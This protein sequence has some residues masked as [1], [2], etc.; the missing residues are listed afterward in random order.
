VELT[1]DDEVSDKNVAEENNE[2]QVNNKKEEL[3]A[4]G[5]DTNANVNGN[6][7]AAVAETVEDVEMTETVEEGEKGETIGD[8]FVCI[9]EIGGS[10]AGDMEVDK[11]QESGG[12]K[13]VPPVSKDGKTKEAPV[14]DINRKPEVG[15][16]K[17]RVKDVS[18]VRNTVLS[19]PVTI[20]NMKWRIMLMPQYTENDGGRIVRNAGI[21][22]QCDPEV[23]GSSWLCQGHGKITVK[24]KAHE[25]LSK[26]ITEGIFTNEHSCWGH[27]SFIPWVDLLD[28]R[29]GFSQNDRVTIEAVVEVDPPLFFQSA[30]VY[31]NKQSAQQTPQAT[32]EHDA[33]KTGRKRKSSDKN[34]ELLDLLTR[35][36]EELTVKVE[37]ERSCA[38]VK[39]VSA[40]AVKQEKSY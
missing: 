23:E 10:E 16:I 22:V 21:F 31:S 33:A 5:K 12:E 1:A 14:T 27:S 30:L 40:T 11:V 2:L 19:D 35:K 38:T 29:K 8:A 28:N 3:E 13:E 24:N 4:K 34:N 6:Q 25:D 26:K 36:K 20:Q 37:R 15:K 39:T 7:E 17:F 32:S 18:R 9:D